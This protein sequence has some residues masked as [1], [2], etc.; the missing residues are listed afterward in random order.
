M[1]HPESHSSFIFL[2]QIS[3]WDQEGHALTSYESEVPTPQTKKAVVRLALSCSACV[4][5]QK[6]DDEEVLNISHPKTSSRKIP[7]D[8]LYAL[9][10]C[11]SS[12]LLSSRYSRDS[13]SLPAAAA[14]G[15]DC[16]GGVP[17]WALNLSG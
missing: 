13:P 4:L 8:T 9:F 1:F 12:Q 7:T 10:F 11:S 14:A 16:G 15:Q 5:L 6:H 3:F 2:L 17:F